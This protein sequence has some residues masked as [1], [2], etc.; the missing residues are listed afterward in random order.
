MSDLNL[1]SLPK[2]RLTKSEIKKIPETPGVYIFLKGKDALYIGKAINLRSRLSSYL[3]TNI[4]PKT[5]SMIRESDNLSYIKVSSELEALLLEAA[6]IRGK[7]PVYN[8]VS[9]DDKHPLY[10][11]ITK[12]D[13]PRV[14]TARKSDIKKGAKTSF[15]PFPSSNNVRSVVKMLRRIIPFSDHKLGKKPCIYSQIGLCNP[16]PSQIEG[17]GYANK[18]ELRGL[19]KKNIRM[20]TSILSGRSKAVIASLYKEMKV[21]SQKLKYERAAEIKSKI[22]RLEYITQPITP[23]SSFIENPNLAEDI[24]ELESSELRKLLSK[25]IGHLPKLKRIEC[26][27]VAHL[28]GTK[29]TASMVTFI[30]GEPEKHL[31]RHFRI[32]STKKADDITSL[33]E[34]AKRRHK[35]LGSWGRPDLILVDGGKAQVAVFK[36]IFSKDGIPVVGLAKRL[37]TLIIPFPKGVMANFA[38]VRV[39]PPA[40]NLVQR[41]RDEAHRF[42]RRYHHL[43]LKKSLLS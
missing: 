25:Y 34:V 1:A 33:S 24:Y 18:D 3:I 13:Y 22:E 39:R 10:I 20:L 19:Y 17:S 31:Y 23:A 32:K 40:L 11:K 2:I 12:E 21:Y 43:L 29:Q 30:G 27:D 41:I 9:K 4:G 8:T 14:I 5:A 26:Y 35:A 28:A 6:L 16:C 37:E 42:A 36:E 38:Q 7:Q 15:G